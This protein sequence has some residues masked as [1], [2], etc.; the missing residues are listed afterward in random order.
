V[1]YGKGNTTAGYVCNHTGPRSNNPTDPASLFADQ[2]AIDA[3]IDAAAAGRNLVACVAMDYSA[4]AGVND[5][6][7]F[8]R[9]LI[10]GPGGDL[11]PSVNLDGRGEKFVPGTCVVCHGGNRYAGE[12][13]TD[14]TGTVDLE[15]HFLP[16]DTA[17]FGFHSTRPELTKAAQQE[18]IFH[19]NS[20]VLNTNANAAMTELINGWYAASHVQNEGFIPPDITV[21]TFRDFYMNVIARSCRTCHIAQRD[22]LS[23][24]SLNFSDQGVNV[25]RPGRL[26]PSILRELIC[27]DT[28]DLVRAYAMPN[29]TVTFDRFWLSRGSSNDQVQRVSDRVGV[30]CTNPKA[31]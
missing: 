10:F 24:R 6:K 7:P 9:F 11:L 5:G 4:T 2:A 29:S 28:D 30:A 3:A 13:P 23:I 20:N 16:F 18:S 26:N 12:F 25:N 17:N 19:L 31:L 1:T 27:G 8:T 22:E 15:A 14:G 21:P